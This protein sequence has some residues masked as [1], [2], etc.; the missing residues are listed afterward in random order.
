MT[1]EI[2]VDIEFCG[3]PLQVVKRTE[4]VGYYKEEVVTYEV[5]VDGVVKHPKCEPEDVIRALGHY[6]HCATKQVT[7]SG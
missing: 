7:H 3:K 1:P 2:I 6:M 4:L 5:V